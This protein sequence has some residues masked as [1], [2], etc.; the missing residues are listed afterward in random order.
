[1]G[2]VLTMILDRKTTWREKFI[3][4][5]CRGC[6]RMLATPFLVLPKDKSYIFILGCYSS[7]T[8]LLNNLLGYH[9]EISGLPTE[10]ASLT[11]ELVTPEELGWTR[12]IH[13]CFT[14]LCSDLKRINPRRLKKQ[15]G[16]FHDKSKLF[17][18]EKSISNWARI[19]WLAKNFDNAWFIWIIRN[20]YAVAEGLRRR[21]IESERYTAKKYPNGFPIELCAQEWVVSN[22]TIES[23]SK[24]IKNKIM[25]KYEELTE[26]K[27]VTIKYILEQLPIKNKMIKINDSFEFHGK[28]RPIKNMNDQSIARLSEE[29]IDKINIVAGDYLEKWGYPV[30]RNPKKR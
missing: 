12:M 15:W 26:D 23:L 14:D 17:F 11:G 13:Q 24:P 25:I 1:M 9:S 29:D 20:G 16:F 18:L 4:V 3:P 8:T 28:M 22:S 27:E 5:F 30:V 6:F 2:M 21:S 19:D 7:G 10:G